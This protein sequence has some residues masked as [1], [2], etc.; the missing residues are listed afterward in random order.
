[1]QTKTT[2]KS[3]ANVLLVVL[4]TILI[5][6]LLGATVLRNTNTRLNVSTNQVRAWKDALL[7]AEAGGDFGFAEIRKAKGNTG[8][9]WTGWTQVAATTTTPKKYIRPDTTFGSGNLI[10][11]TV[12]EEIYFDSSTG[13]MRSTPLSAT[14]NPWYRVRSRGTA[15][16]P[17]L[18]QTGMDDTI[19]ADGFAH[20]ATDGT[21]R[22][23]GD[24]L[25]RKIDFRYDHFVASYGP[26]GDGL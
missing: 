8:Y 20:F 19:V 15:P 10:T 21:A 12:V 5:V 24:S 1:M 14:A 23:K 7:A 22:G 2:T 11:R 25:L 6:S 9:P 17:G 4:G 18:K 3:S 26:N 13:Q 16:L